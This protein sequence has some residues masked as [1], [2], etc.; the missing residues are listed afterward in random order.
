VSVRF[1]LGK[2]WA[3]I[4]IGQLAMLV[5][6]TGYQAIADQGNGGS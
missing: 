4:V 1:D 2:G 5:V 3:A 6:I